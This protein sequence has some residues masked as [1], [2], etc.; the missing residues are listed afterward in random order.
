MISRPF[1]LAWLRYLQPAAPILFSPASPDKYRGG[2]QSGRSSCVGWWCR[3]VRPRCCLFLRQTVQYPAQAC[4]PSP[5]GSLPPGGDWLRG[6]FQGSWDWS[7]GSVQPSDLNWRGST[8]AVFI[9]LFPLLE[10]PPDNLFRCYFLLLLVH[11]SKIIMLWIV[12]YL[13][14]LNRNPSISQQ[15][16]IEINQLWLQSWWT[17][18]FATG[19]WLR[20]FTH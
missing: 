20:T 5:L 7:W 1:I 10:C 8:E 17:K 11:Y 18:G 2:V 15:A 16:E 4:I 3:S 19:K 13:F 14:D 9:E 12:S 6:G